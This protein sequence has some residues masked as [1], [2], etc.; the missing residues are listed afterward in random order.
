M[1]DCIPQAD[2][3]EIDAWREELIQYGID[4][5]TGDSDSSDP[6]INR[7]QDDTLDIATED[8]AESG[9]PLDEVMTDIRGETVRRVAAADRDAN[10][11]IYDALEYEYRRGSALRLQILGCCCDYRVCYSRSVSNLTGKNRLS[12]VNAFL[13][14]SR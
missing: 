14:S 8:G 9:S 1:T 6:T 10:R 4:E 5:L 12:S 13:P 2:A 3:G 7:V 11:G